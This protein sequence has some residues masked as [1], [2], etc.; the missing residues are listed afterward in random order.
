LHIQGGPFNG[1]G[2]GVGTSAKD[3]VAYPSPDPA[4]D[5]FV[6]KDSSFCRNEDLPEYLRGAVV[7]AGEY[8]GVAL[9]ARRGPDS[10]GGVR[11]LVGD[12]NTDD[13]ISFLMY[14]KAPSTQ[15]NCE[16][17]RECACTNHKA[18]QPWE[19]PPLDMKTSNLTAWQKAVEAERIDL[20][21]QMWSCT[22]AGMYCEDPTADIIPGYFPTGG[23]T[24]RCNTCEKTRCA[25]PYEAYP[26]GAAGT[27]VKDDQFNDKPCTPYTSRSGVSSAYCFDPKLDPPPAEQDQQCGDH[28][29]RPIYLTDQWQLHL[30]PFS[31]MLQQGWAKR[32][33]KMDKSHVTLVRLTWDGGYI[34]YWVGWIGFYRYK[35]ARS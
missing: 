19:V 9:W 5:C 4:F 3:W 31:D 21:Y 32:F 22:S 18:C 10:Q 6:N 17:V 1:W 30:V 13:D 20:T 15:R 7:N 34:D 27:T 26:D 16:R 8:E 2:G 12:I 11:V 28:W 29:T 14:T 33:A 25:E 35:G 23:M 24:T